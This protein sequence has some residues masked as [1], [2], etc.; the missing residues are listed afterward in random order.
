MMS[1]KP[2]QRNLHK[3]FSKSSKR[4][5]CINQHNSSLAPYKGHAYH[6]FKP[7]QKSLN[8]K[9]VNT[10][11]SDYE[12]MLSHYS[13]VFVVRIEL[14]PNTYSADNKVIRQFLERLTTFLSGEYQSKVIYHCAREQDTAKQEHYHL[15]LMLSAHKINYSDRIQ[16]LVEAMWEMHANGTVAFVDNPFCIVYRGDKASLKGAIY[17]SSYFAKEHTKEL[18]GKACGLLR[19]KLPPAKNFDPTNDLM[20]VDPYITLEKNRRKQAF[21]VAQA[22][23]S[24]PRSNTSKP[25]KYGWFNTLTHMQQLNECIASRTTSLN[26]LGNTP[27]FMVI[28]STNLS[29]VE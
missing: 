18:N 11:I 28:N 24:Q 9:M 21:E 15:E 16:S 13:R 17:R 6:V 3:P 14:H 29:G 12:I 19:N 27:L 20:L 2:K 1:I 22:T 5:F 10:I 4:F 26:H 7:K 25:S 23:E 8:K